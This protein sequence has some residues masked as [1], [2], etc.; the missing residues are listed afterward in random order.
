MPMRRSRV[1]YSRSNSFPD[2][3]KRTR[4]AKKIQLVGTCRRGSFVKDKTTFIVKDVQHV[5]DSAWS[6]VYRTLYNRFQPIRPAGVNT[7]LAPFRSYS[8]TPQFIC[9]PS[10]RSMTPSVYCSIFCLLFPSSPII[11]FLYWNLLHPCS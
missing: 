5:C 8:G 7:H 11:L 1:F 10:V 2:N 6:N 3:G 4:T 9:S